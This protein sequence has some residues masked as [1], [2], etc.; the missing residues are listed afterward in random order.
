MINI[1]YKIYLNV[2]KYDNILQNSIYT[3]N[4]NKNKIAELNRSRRTWPL[5]RRL[6]T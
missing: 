2:K 4:K 5:L 1:N 3:F 6:K